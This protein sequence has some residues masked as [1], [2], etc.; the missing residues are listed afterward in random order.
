[1]TRH[2]AVV[3][4]AVAAAAI[5]LHGC[6]GGGGSPVVR[7]DPPAPPPAPPA[8]LP[9]PPVPPPAPPPPPPPPSPPPA[10]LVAPGGSLPPSY[11]GPTIAEDGAEYYT[12]D[13]VGDPGAY[14]Y[15]GG[16]AIRIGIQDDAVDFTHPDFRGRIELEGARFAYRK[17]GLIDDPAPDAFDHCDA[18]NRCRI[19]L[20]DSTGDRSTIE[21]LARTVLEDQGLP[22][23][24]NRRFL[25]D[26]AES[27]FGWFELPALGLDDP[28]LGAQHGTGVASVAARQAPDAALVPMATNFRD[29]FEVTFDLQR[30][31]VLRIQDD[32]WLEDSY[33][34][35][36]ETDSVAEID[37]TLAAAWRRWY[38]SADI[39]NSSFS[40]DLDLSTVDGRRTRDHEFARMRTLNANLHERWK[41]RTQA[42]RPEEERTIRVL[43][44][45]NERDSAG[46][47]ARSLEVLVVREFEELW[48]HNVVATALNE[49]ETALADY[50]NVCGALPPGWDANRHGRHFC[51]AAPGV[52]RVALPG[53][54]HDEDAV[55]TSFAA[56]YV[57]GVLARMMAQSRGQVGNTELVK[58]MMDTADIS[59]VFGNRSLYGAGVVDPHAALRAV[60]APTTGTSRNRAAIGSTALRL[61][62]AYGDAARHVAGTE[63]ASF[64]AWNFPF[65][66]PAGELIA[67]GARP[68][69]PIPD[70]AEADR[71]GG[72][73]VTSGYAPD[74]VCVPPASP[75]AR[76]A[77]PAGAGHGGAFGGVSGLVA[78]GGA[79]AS[80]RLSES[81]T[82][83]GFARSAGRLDGR[84]T[85]A[86]SF[87]GGSSLGA[88]HFERSH[89]IDDAGI[90]RLDGGVTF[91]FD[92]PQGIGQSEGSM[93]EAGPALLS[94]WRI[95]LAHSGG[96]TRTRLTVSQ[97]PRAESGTGR[98]TFPSGRR[99]DGTHVHASRTFSLRPTRRMVTAALVHRRPFAGGE[100]VAMLYH[101]RNAGHTTAAPDQG[102]GIAWRLAF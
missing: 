30:G 71:A 9:A 23:D 13:R 41:A 55:G 67:N 90:W 101:A 54:S 8:P 51:L 64:D 44:A 18:S 86:F 1:M 52:H 16:D 96:D 58:R 92:V 15:P 40:T 59:G 63:I 81:V 53:G 99:L 78:A 3:C 100:A 83:A 47:D 88:V 85:G 66:T 17:L 10:P 56:P 46:A 65:W 76:G 87:A 74:A 5:G 45:G 25:H 6:G 50:A 80:V 82:V 7:P 12:V 34:E 70:F 29:R 94:S 11:Q 102:G 84:A 35:L 60:G 19:Y 37:R 33:L 42:D 39:I 27:G 49:A 98:L 79:G 89:A 26:I 4:A 69:D 57:S 36:A 22:P 72:C 48:G 43:A 31:T 61:P 24:T 73:F 95:G 28:E 21:A 38:E 77:L 93:F 75:S 68:I 2:G 32:P 62:A 14:A 91:A 20:V 97:P